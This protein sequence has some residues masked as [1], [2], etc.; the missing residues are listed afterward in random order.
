MVLAETDTTIRVAL[1]DAAAEQSAPQSF[2][3][4]HIFWSMPP[5]QLPDQQTV[6]RVA[7]A[8]LVDAMLTGYNVCMFAYG[9]TS[10]GKTFSMMGY[11]DPE[12]RGI[13]PRMFDDMFGRIAE[14]TSSGKETRY[15]VKV[16]PIC[17]TR[18][19]VPKLAG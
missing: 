2:V 17:T 18:C 19:D 15:A 10:G 12:G 1:P 14:A 16:C 9:Q 4:D 8:P 11:G 6:Y 13:I 3:F 5:T 7:G